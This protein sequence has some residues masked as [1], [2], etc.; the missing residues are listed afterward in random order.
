MRKTFK[1]ALGA[2]L[3]G[4]M[5]VSLLAGCGGGGGVGGDADE[6]YTMWIYSGQDAAYYLDYEEN[7]ALQY[8]LQKTYGPDEKTLAIDFWVPPSGS[9]AD[10][11]STMIGSGDLPDVIDAS[12]ADAPTVMYETGMIMDLTELIPEYM[13]NY[14][15]YLEEHPEI[16]HKAYV[17]IDGE[18]KMLFIRSFEE[19]YGYNFCGVEYR[20]DWIAK[21]GTNP[22]TGAAFTGEFTDE[23]DPDSWVDDVVFPSGGSDPIYISDWEWMFEIFDKAMEA[24][25]I[26]D[27]YCLSIYYP[28][29][30]WNGNFTS[31]FG[32]GSP[33]WYEDLDGNVMFGADSPQFRA[34]LECLNTWYSKG[35]IDQSF[36]QRTSDA[37]YSIDDTTTRQGKVGLWVGLESQLGGRMDVGA[38]EYT[39]GIC[40]YG[41][42]WPINDVYGDASCQNVEPNAVDHT[43][44]AGTVWYVTSA[45]E[46][47]DLGTLLS[48]FDYFYTEEGAVL[49]T[50]GLSKE[51]VE[52]TQN[53]VYLD[54]GLENG[55]YSVKED[56]T[57]LLDEMLQKDSGGLAKAAAFTM[58][59][60]ITLVSSVDKGYAENYE[61]SMSLWTLYPNTTFFQ[62]SDVTG[63]MTEADTKSVTN[64]QSKIL[65]YMTVNAPN[66]IMGKTDPYDDGDWNDWCT[67]LGKY[68]Y[69]KVNDVVQPYADKYE[70]D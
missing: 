28:G 33:L 43:S 32:G 51:Q 4:A 12:I 3:G 55:A 57:Y 56:G 64:I 29:F 40:S 27:G 17:D 68:G 54:N 24:E 35:W 18:E 63:Y 42:P 26:T 6:T 65:D 14:M 36:N 10:N 31:C 58:V 21:Y 53:Q 59:P 13:P 34:Y 46:G 1:R 47:K 8:A 9:A 61:H 38:S 45:A 52:E 66:F 15:K 23:S 5:A 39:E 22:E 2:V 69:T 48:F 20:R 62:G 19:D 44:L 60:G 25:G 70:I 30:T 16:A 7:P 49:K 41:A 11:Y 37:H 50:L 67:M